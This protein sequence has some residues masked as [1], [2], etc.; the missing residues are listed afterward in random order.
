MY[1][2]LILQET[3]KP[4]ILLLLL[5]SPAAA[6]VRPMRQDEVYAEVGWLRGEAPGSVH[7]WTRYGGK[8]I[9]Q[10]LHLIITVSVYMFFFKQQCFAHWGLQD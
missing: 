3:E 2:V 1:S 5:G 10:V 9:L 7:H 8:F 6:D 4:C